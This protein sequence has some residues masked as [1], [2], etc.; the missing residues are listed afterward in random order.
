MAGII[1]CGG[2]ADDYITRTGDRLL[3]KVDNDEAFLMGYR[4]KLSQ[5]ADG[6]Q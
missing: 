1:T 5:K 3:I 6:H 2:P 4:I